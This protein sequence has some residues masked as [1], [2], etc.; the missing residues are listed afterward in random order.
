MGNLKLHWL[1]LTN[2]KTVKLDDIVI[3]TDKNQMPRSVRTSLFKGTHEAH[4]RLLVAKYLGKS[5]RV[6]EIG[7]ATGLV[8]LVCAKQCGAQNVRSY[9]ANPSMEKL[10][11]K[12]FQLNGWVPDLHMKAVTTEGGTISFFASDNIYSSSIID[13]SETVS[14]KTITVESDPIDDVI[15]EFKPNV[16]VMDVEGAEIDL[17]GHANLSG[18]Q[19]MIVELHPHIT[20]QDKVDELLK[21]LGDS[22]F[23]ILETAHKTVFLSK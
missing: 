23:S 7:A 13:R 3:S 18:I 19:R 8:S 17:L 22:G 6:L 5:D 21:L 12:N 14:G 10:I 16:I 20:G 4:E 9:E 15:D 11:R 2:A 1:R